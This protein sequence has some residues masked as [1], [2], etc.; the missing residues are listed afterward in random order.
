MSLLSFFQTT[1]VDVVKVFVAIKNEEAVLAK[2]VDAALKWI[3]G[4]SAVIQADLAKVEAIVAALGLTGNPAVSASV[5]AASIAATEFIK[6]AQAYE[7]GQS[8]AATVAVGYQAYTQ[9]KAAVATAL[10]AATAK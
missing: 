7:S 5:V 9:T 2:K 4:N 6:F 8:T 10:A 1:E 3:A